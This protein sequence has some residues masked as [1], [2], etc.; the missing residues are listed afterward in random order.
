[1]VLII[2]EIRLDSDIRDSRLRFYFRS[3]SGSSHPSPRQQSNTSTSQYPDRLSVSL[4]KGTRRI[5][6]PATHLSAIHFNR[7]DGYVKVEGDGWAAV[8]PLF[9]E[10]TH[11]LRKYSQRILT[12][13][14]L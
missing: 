7:N 3:S 6:I 2:E 1:L 14:L 5:V 4:H 13:L 8:F 10:L 11:S 9:L 12:I